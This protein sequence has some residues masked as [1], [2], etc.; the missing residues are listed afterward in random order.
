MCI[1]FND[2]NSCAVC[3]SCVCGLYGLS[4]TCPYCT[5]GETIEGFWT[6]WLFPPS[7]PQ[8]RVLDDKYMFLFVL[9]S[10]MHS[11][12]KC[13]CELFHSL[14]LTHSLICSLYFIL[15]LKVDEWTKRLKQRKS[16][17][18]YC[19]VKSITCGCTLGD[20]CVCVWCT[21]QRDSQ[22]DFLLAL[23]QLLLQGFACCLWSLQMYL[24]FSLP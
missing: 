12:F 20:V 15:Q 3:V 1:W 5:S 2:Y 17:K 19:C 23:Y 7:T 14:S 18:V 22:Q 9:S 10:I 16:L 21:A 4:M 11:S 24:N 6:I 13:W 8:D